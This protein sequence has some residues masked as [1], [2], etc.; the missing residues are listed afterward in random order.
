MSGIALRYCNNETDALAAINLAFLKV[1][2]KLRQY[3]RK[4]SLATWIKKIVI[5]HLIDDYRRNRKFYQVHHFG[6]E[7]D[8]GEQAVQN[9]GPANLE[10]EELLALLRTLPDTT[11]KVF[12]L[13]AIDGYKHSEISSLMEMSEGTS[14]WHVNRA[15]KLL[16]ERVTAMV[17]SEKKRIKLSLIG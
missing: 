11:R 7:E 9:L 13:F 10:A 6:E 15:R 8:E 3:D 17:E 1:L 5:Q 12:A 2:K 4:Y 14:K 16:R